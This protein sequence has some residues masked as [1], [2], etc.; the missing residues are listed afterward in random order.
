MIE[1][2]IRSA[3]DAIS[4]SCAARA[5]VSVARVWEEAEYEVK[6]FK[7]SLI[8]SLSVEVFTKEKVVDFK[9]A[10]NYSINPEINRVKGA[11]FSK[12]NLSGLLSKY[13]LKI[14]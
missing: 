7:L 1:V 14:T 8:I 10:Q 9:T 11:K 3:I 5:A 12:N 4:L 6:V 13:Q 2:E